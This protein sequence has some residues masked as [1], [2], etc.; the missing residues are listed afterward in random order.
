MANEEDYVKLGLLCAEVCEA[1]HQELKGRKQEDLS[2]S[3]LR[4][5]ERLAA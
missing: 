4:A 1:L 3:T 2:Q 5:I